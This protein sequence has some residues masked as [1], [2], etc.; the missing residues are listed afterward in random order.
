M[1][2]PATTEQIKFMLGKV[3]ESKGFVKAAKVISGGVSLEILSDNA[4]YNMSSDLFYMGGVN[5]Y[6][7]GKWAELISK[8]EPKPQ[9]LV[10]KDVVL[11]D[12][13][14]I[15]EDSNFEIKQYDRADLHLTA[16]HL[17][18]LKAYFTA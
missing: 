7:K 17:Q 5:V 1:K 9:T 6:S 4:N 11:S 2:Q 13:L 16:A 10:L 15:G 8:E 18:Q 14:S 12:I 3:A